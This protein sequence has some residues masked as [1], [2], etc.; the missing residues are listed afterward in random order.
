MFSLSGA[1]LYTH[2]LGRNGSHE[3]LQFAFFVSQTLI[4]KGDQNSIQKVQIGVKSPSN[5]QP[6]KLKL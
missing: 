6:L 4:Y 3:L 5:D 1:G 2:D